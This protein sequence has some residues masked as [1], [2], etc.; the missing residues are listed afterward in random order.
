MEYKKLSKTI[1]V[2]KRIPLP[3]KMRKYKERDFHRHIILIKGNKSKTKN[4]PKLLNNE[5]QKCIEDKNQNIKLKRNK[6]I[7]N[8]IIQKKYDIIPI[9]SHNSEKPSK[10]YEENSSGK[11]YPAIY[12]FDKNNKK[13][14]SIIKEKKY[15]KIPIIIHESESPSMSFEEIFGGKNNSNIQ[16]SLT[17]YNKKFVEIPIIVHNSEKPSICFEE[18]FGGKKNSIVQSSQTNY[19]KKRKKFDEIPSIVHKSEKP[20]ISFEEINSGKINS[21]VKYSDTYIREANNLDKNKNKS[22]TYIEVLI[23]AHDS[24]KPSIVFEEIAS[25]NKKNIYHNLITNYKESNKFKLKYK[26]IPIVVHNSERP[27]IIFEETNAGIQAILY[28]NF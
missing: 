8:K 27:T 19:G 6:T 16:T 22:K 28:H 7:E 20:S 11:L 25:I 18:A 14:T 9:I 5:N 13:E 4:I 10:I 21:M 12:N 1:G 2:I 26:K 17:K 23:I 3:F 15:E 24:E